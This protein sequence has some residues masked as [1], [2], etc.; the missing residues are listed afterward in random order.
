M[1]D[2]YDT[3]AKYVLTV[4]AAA[5]FAFLAAIIFGDPA[6]GILTAVLAVSLISMVLFLGQWYRSTQL[7]ALRPPLFRSR[8]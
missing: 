6:P 3:L 2:H 7:V 8:T 5:V 4:L 1:L